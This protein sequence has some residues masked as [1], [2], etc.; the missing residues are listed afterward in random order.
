M[1]GYPAD[2][3]PD[4]EAMAMKTVLLVTWFYL[5]QPPV[6]SQTVFDTEQACGRARVAV[7]MD[8]ERLKTEALPQPPG[9][10]AIV[11]SYPTVSVVCS[12][13]Q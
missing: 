1:S 11:P 10:H 4:G 5:N 2:T 9:Y 7:L 6:V 8:A 12:P 3:E 13:L